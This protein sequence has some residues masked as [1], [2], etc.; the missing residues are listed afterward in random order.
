MG[1]SPLDLDRFRQMLEYLND[2]AYL[3]DRTR[4]VLL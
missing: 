1:T 2:G 4:G 3:T